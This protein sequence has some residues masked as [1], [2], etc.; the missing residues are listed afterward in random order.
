MIYHFS[1]YTQIVEN[2]NKVVLGNRLNGEWIRISKEVYNIL[3]MGIKNKL[4]ISEL[5]NCLYD[6]DDKNYLKSLYKDMCI[7]CRDHTLK[8]GKTAWRTKACPILTLQYN[9]ATSYLKSKHKG[10]KIKDVAAC[11]MYLI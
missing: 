4:S 7:W 10:R 9:N 3:E 2:N 11:A 6:N 5:I 1:K 8:S